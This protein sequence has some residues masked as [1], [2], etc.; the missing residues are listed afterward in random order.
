MIS[1]LLGLRELSMTC[2]CPVLQLL[3]HLLVESNVLLPVDEKIETG[4]V[5]IQAVAILCLEGLKQV[6]SRLKKLQ[7]KIF[8]HRRELLVKDTNFL[9][10]LIFSPSL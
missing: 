8:S 1:R 9:I 4:D 7:N 2:F 5:G 10:L 3:G 6:M